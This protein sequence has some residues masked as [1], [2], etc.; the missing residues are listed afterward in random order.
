MQERVRGG[1][2][3]RSDR[4]NDRKKRI[5]KRNTEKGHRADVVRVEDKG[6]DD[7]RGEE[8]RMED[9]RSREKQ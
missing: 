6:L 2:W 1:W 4:E 9:K 8:R 7:Q 5:K 3:K